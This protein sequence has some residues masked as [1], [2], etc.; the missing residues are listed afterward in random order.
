MDGEIYFFALQSIASA[1]SSFFT[2][3]PVE[4]LSTRV[5]ADATFSRH[6]TLQHGTAAGT[7]ALI[8]KRACTLEALLPHPHT[9]STLN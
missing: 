8:G 4:S 9:H 3:Q 2:F 5:T 7:F 1:A 6:S